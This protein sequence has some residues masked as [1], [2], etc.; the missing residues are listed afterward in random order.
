MDGVHDRRSIGNIVDVADGRTQRTDRRAAI[1]S[2][3]QVRH[4]FLAH[5]LIRC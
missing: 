3:S 2:R 4:P 5:V 1:V